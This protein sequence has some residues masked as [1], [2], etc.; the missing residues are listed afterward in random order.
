MKKSSEYISESVFNVNSHY[1]ELQNK[2]KELFFKCLNENRSSEYFRQEVN[3]LWGNIDH[4]FMDKQIDK[5]QSLVWENNTKLAID[6]GRIDNK[7]IPTEKWV[8]DKEYF[9]LVPED[10]FNQLEREFERQVIK[11]YDRS[12]KAIQGQDKETYIQ[13]KLERY[14]EEINQ[15]IAYFKDGEPIR[16]VQLS[17]YLSMLHNTNLTRAGWNQTLSDSEKLN[18]DEFI[19]PYHPFSC[20]HCYENQNIVLSRAEVENLINMTLE[21]GL[22]SNGELLHPNCKCTLSIYWSIDQIQ[23]MI[24]TTEENKNMYDIRQKV[25]SLTLE[26]SRIISDMK[27]QKEL[28]NEEAYDKLNQ[29]RNAINEKIRE[30]KEQLPTESL[31]KQVGAINR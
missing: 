18:K 1:T 21:E 24:Y 15:T 20:P 13:K 14:N 12:L 7:F 8:I 19:I 11:N 4:R 23:P 9:K 17:T 22:E 29:R 5:L 10:Q 25:N 2:T 3:K 27:T 30:L 6:I 26:K 28:G 16:H 31:Q